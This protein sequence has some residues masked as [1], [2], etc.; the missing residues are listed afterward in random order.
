MIVS[1]ENKLNHQAGRS[2]A[3]DDYYDTYAF[4]NLWWVKTKRRV[5]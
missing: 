2:I 5:R 3:M 1:P 4:Q